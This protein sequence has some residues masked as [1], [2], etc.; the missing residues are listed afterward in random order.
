MTETSEVKNDFKISWQM[1]KANYNAFLMTELFA[2][3]SFILS[4]VISISLFILIYIS[5]PAYTF[6]DFITNI[7]QN[8]DFRYS[9]IGTIFFGLVHAL[10]V[11]FLNCQYG[12]AYDI[13][14]SGDMFS[15]FKRAFNYFKRFWWQYMLLSFISGFSFFI[16]P[17]NVIF[18]MVSPIGNIFYDLGLVVFQFLIFFT[19]LVLSNSILPSIT[20]QGNFNNGIIETLRLLNKDFKRIL[21]TWGL[22]YLIFIFPLVAIVLVRL[23]LFTF[24]GNGW[25]LMVIDI[26]AL[27]LYLIY[28]LI[29]YPLKTLIATR[30]YNSVEFDRFKPFLSN[31][32]KYPE[33]NNHSI[34]SNNSGE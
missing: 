8:K 20:S 17:R 26:L 19:F 1:L 32:T 31:S 22:Y 11:G 7:I 33:E 9:W 23:E 2:I 3:I 16:P 4:S 12:L 5:L 15:E 34:D 24:I 18:H 13:M 27:I 29:G 14:S 28:V 10:M 25:W 30:I 6:D 21:K